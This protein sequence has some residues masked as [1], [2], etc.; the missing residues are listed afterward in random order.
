MKIWAFF[1]LAIVSCSTAP[2]II[3][4]QGTDLIRAAPDPILRVISE[5]RPACLGMLRTFCDNLYAPTNQ[6]TLAISLKGTALEVRKGQTAN[7]FSQVYFEYAETQIRFRERLPA[8]F[9][10]ILANLGYFGKLRSYLS[11]KPRRVMTLEDRSEV[12]RV[13]HEIESLWKS[14]IGE[15]T[16]KRMEKIHP[17]YS[18]I[19]EDLIPMELTYEAT[20]V[21]GN[22][23]SEIAKA[24]W[25][26]H[27]KWKE[28]E[29]Q[30]SEVREAFLHII[31]NHAGLSPDIKRDWSERI[32]ASRLI[33]PGS[34]PEVDMHACSRT[35]ENAYYYTNRNYLTVCAGDFNSEDVRHTL[36]HELAHSLDFNRS[37][38]IFEG[39][40]PL[41]VRLSQLRKNNCAAEA[42]SCAEWRAFK[43]AF[44]EDV[45]ALE[46]FE[47]QLPEFQ[48]CLKGGP[49]ISPI[50]DDYLARVAKE[51][52][53]KAISGL[54]EKNAFL[55]MIS[56]A[57]PAPNGKSQK[58]PM[59]LNPCGYY[60]W[61][62]TT[63]LFDEELTGLLFFTSE[64]RCGADLPSPDR[65]QKALEKALD[66]Q[67]ELFYERMKVEG[68]FS[69]KTRLNADG[70]ASSPTERFADALA[71]L[72]FARLL[73]KE[74]DIVKRR[75]FYLE[76]NAWLCQRPSLQQSMPLEAGI[77]R[78]FY[79]ESHSEESLRQKELLPEEIRKA[80]QCEKDF[81]LD[82]CQI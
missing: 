29:N 79:V 74:P 81:E 4:P 64:Y 62:S 35:E 1:F 80:L 30:F 6:G 38:T 8:D 47:I 78:K 71:G 61:D 59:Y 16:L 40:S 7:D 34:D 73:E 75:A 55:R 17:G 53:Q 27:P 58:N 68:E 52:A 43:D 48:S 77:Q 20:R 24:V 28:V 39:L 67:T 22:L 51:R 14:A 82:E 46:K 42:F 3:P 49:T 72:V 26:E 54:A 76:N 10:S 18:S 44:S 63:D 70:Y 12:I 5:E 50:P 57:L 23:V 33:V 37:L 65:F 13:A 69:S 60:V 56:K 31:Q 41:G 2:V 45:R 19:R 25:T 66:M 15:A 11:R 36:S 21:R 32:Q 9:R